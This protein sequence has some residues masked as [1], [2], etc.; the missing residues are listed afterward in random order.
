MPIISSSCFSNLAAHPA[1]ALISPGETE[2]T[3]EERER[4]A[5]KQLY[6]HLKQWGQELMQTLKLCLKQTAAA[7]QGGT[8]ARQP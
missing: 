1:S 6:L 3:E 5:L 4:G 8:A 7:L 2:G